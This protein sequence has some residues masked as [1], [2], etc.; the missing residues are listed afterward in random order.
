MTA[1][2]RCGPTDSDRSTGAILVEAGR[3]K[4]EDV[5]RVL[6]LQRDQRLRF[7]EAAVRLGVVAAADIEFA[8][9]LQF[10]YR[11]L[12]RGRSSVSEN[13]VAAYATSGP[14]LEALRALR[15]QLMQRWFDGAPA[16][17]AL[18][19]LSA[20]RGEGRSFVAASLAVVLSR[21]GQRTLLIDADM[22][23]PAQHALF[24]LDNALGLSAVLAGRSRHGAVRDV[25]DLPELAV[26]P[27]GAVPPNP[28]ELLARPSF[29][30][31]LSD[32]AQSY[33]AILLDT[34]C[35]AE[36]T[37]GHTVAQRCGAALVL[38][39]KSVSRTSSV[40]GVCDAVKQAGATVVG[41]VLNDF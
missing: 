13:L 10:G 19:V 27:A 35:A 7:G 18:A 24:G 6:Q 26:L 38:A 2:E 29:P 21:F 41:T 37:D 40:R 5:A 3:M 4:A 28:Q 39:R 12:V 33:D 20:D 17:K 23:R 34:S 32:L 16:H 1:L 25:A 22:R 14:E 36:C 30:L 8:L 31:L 15:A 9:S 11:C